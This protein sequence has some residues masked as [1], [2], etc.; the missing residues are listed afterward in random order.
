MTG[1]W[2]E[3][4]DQLLS[5]LDSYIA[6]CGGLE[7]VPFD[8]VEHLHQM[9]AWIQT[10]NKDELHKAIEW[11]SCIAPQLESIGTVG[12]QMGNVTLDEGN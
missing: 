1:D 10:A 6:R 12:F 8:Y 2:L 9:K 3:Q 5:D 11:W 7:P 4:K